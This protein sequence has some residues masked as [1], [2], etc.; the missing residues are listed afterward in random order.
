MP[1]PP[2]LSSGSA[3]PAVPTLQPG[4]TN[5]AMAP[6]PAHGQPVPPPPKMAPPV[7]KCPPPPA[8][9]QQVPVIRGKA[10]VRDDGRYYAAGLQNQAGHLNGLGRAKVSGLENAMFVAS[11]RCERVSFA[12][13]FPMGRYKYSQ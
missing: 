1:P 2:K 5:K 10:S 7:L 4:C 13:S 12:T 3:Q 6:G 11:K 9:E 8:Q